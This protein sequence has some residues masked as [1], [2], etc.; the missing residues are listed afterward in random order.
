MRRYFYSL[1]LFFVLFGT[2]APAF[3]ATDAVIL[4]KKKPAIKVAPA[5]K[6]A[7]EKSAPAK[8][9]PP[10]P[11]QK[12]A[13]IN[14][15]DNTTQ[16]EDDLPPAVDT[17]ETTFPDYPKGA[18]PAMGKMQTYTTDEQD[19]LLDIA[20]YFDLG[21]VEARAANLELDPWTPV[22]GTE[23]EIPNFHLLPRAPQEGI[24]VN[25][26]EMRLYYFKKP[27]EE[28]ITYPIGIGRDGLQTPVG[29]TTIIRKGEKP[30]WY[31]TARMREEKPF[32]PVAVPPGPSNPLGEYALYLGWAEFRIHGSNKP[33]A[34]GRRV[35]S[36][37]MRM[38]P[39]DIKALYDM[40][41][42]GTKVTIVDQ[43]IMLA[44][45][46]SDLYLEAAPSKTQSNDVE[47]LGEFKPKDMDEPLQK[48]IE[49]AAGPHADLIDWDIARRVVHERK[50]YPVVIASLK[51][52]DDADDK[53]ESKKET[54]KPDVRTS[55]Q[56]KQKPGSFNN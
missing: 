40:V 51:K 23:I 34:I 30:I 44:W 16:S 7:A 2:A 48:A 27:G 46:G 25:L 13:A 3:S 52:S 11:G 1:I 19:T 38:Y 18:R 41:P 8:M 14:K 21:F 26:A 6:S 4:P 42:V 39:E 17:D 43:P 47:I 35:S 9:G 55:A 5:G 36:G 33:W 20:R 53:K 24:V 15:T 29:T 54:K 37:C 45:I 56:E 50:G 28:P 31:P 10:A 22:P 12:N 32:L 49:K